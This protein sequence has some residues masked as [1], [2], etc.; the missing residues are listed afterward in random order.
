MV[1]TELVQITEKMGVQLVGSRH[2]WQI[3]S[4][5]LIAPSE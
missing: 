1:S 5:A 4:K 2:E 3:K